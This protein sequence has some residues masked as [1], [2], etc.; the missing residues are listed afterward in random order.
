MQEGATHLEWTAPS[1][2]F[3]GSLLHIVWLSRTYWVAL[4]RRNI[5]RPHRVNGS[6]PVFAVS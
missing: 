3:T 5:H 1:C 2:V 6:H 4:K